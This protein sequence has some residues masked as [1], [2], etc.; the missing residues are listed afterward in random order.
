MEP[1]LNLPID[2]S[3]YPAFEPD[4]ETQVPKEGHHKAI[5]A[6]LRKYAN[7]PVMAM[8]DACIDCG[9]CAGACHYYASVPNRDLIPAVK[10]KRLTG[11]LKKYFQY[12]RLQ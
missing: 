9:Q 1:G 12:H 3:K 7:R 10:A 2:K 8:M 5:Q 4:G 6:A 11:I